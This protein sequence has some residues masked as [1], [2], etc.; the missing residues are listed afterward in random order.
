[1]T[2]IGNILRRTSF[3]TV[4]I[5][6]FAAWLMVD[7]LFFMPN[8]HAA[9][10]TSRKLSVSSTANGSLAAGQGVTYTYTF[11]VPGAASTVQSMD[12]QFCTNPLPGT[13]CNLPTGQSVSGATLGT[14]SGLTGWSLGTAGNAPSNSWSNGTSGTGGRIRLT[15]TN[16]TNVSSDTIT[17]IAFGAI[18]NP[19][20]DNQTFYTR[21]ITYTDTAWTTSRDSGSVANSTA[22][23]ID[24]TAKVQETLN[25]SVGSTVTAPSTTCAP[26]SDSGA[27]ALGDINGVLSFAQAYD[28]HSYFRVS[29]NANNGTVIYYGG[30]TLKS[31]SNSITAVGQSAGGT[32]SAPGTSQFGLAIDS[33]DTQAGSG[34]SFTTLAAATSPNTYAAGNGTITAAGTAK[35]QFTTTSITT[36]VQI[37]SASTPITCDTGSVRYLGNIATTTPPGIYTTTITYYAVPTY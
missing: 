28:A 32:S 37:A 10:I 17:S 18:T 30:D 33:S 21:L 19:T 16:A 6:L 34:Y 11:T 24:I 27:L 4:A 29:T 31:G 1:M 5:V 8:A 13:D 23:Q 7:L 26:F 22:Q 20:T 36:P 12:L 35:F 3:L 15:R 14:V 2:G 9:Q 25:F